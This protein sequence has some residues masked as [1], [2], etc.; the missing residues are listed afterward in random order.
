MVSLVYNSSSQPGVFRSYLLVLTVLHSDVPLFLMQL[1]TT[2]CTQ[3]GLVKFFIAL[4]Q[5]LN[6]L[7]NG[8]N[9]YVGGLGVFGV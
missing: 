2:A 5:N 9:I 7:I 6:V 8:Y 3:T 4:R 1:F